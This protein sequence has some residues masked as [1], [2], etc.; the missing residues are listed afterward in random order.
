[1]SRAFFIMVVL[2]GCVRSTP[3][4][5]EPTAPALR[6]LDFDADLDRVERSPLRLEAVVTITNRRST[7]VTLTFPIACLGLIRAYEGGSSAPVWEQLSGEGCPRQPL[8]LALEPDDERE[9]RIREMSAGEVL[10]QNL[11]EGTY[12]FTVLLEPDGHVLEIEAGEAELERPLGR[13][14]R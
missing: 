5:T 11:P 9:I 3:P 10:G 8:P 1:M 6:G 12:R 13:G 2:L 4:E 14:D 7:P